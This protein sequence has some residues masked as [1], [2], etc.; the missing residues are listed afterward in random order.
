MHLLSDLESIQNHVQ[1]AE[2]EE[3]DLIPASR[4]KIQSYFHSLQEYTESLRLPLMSTASQIPHAITES[5]ALLQDHVQAR[6]IPLKLSGHGT[7]P[8][9]LTVFTSATCK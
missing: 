1:E 9:R 6:Y 3:T 4:V 5:L 8:I 7:T 2:R